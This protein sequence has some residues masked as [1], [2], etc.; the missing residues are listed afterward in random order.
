VAFV[1]MRDS[2]SFYKQILN[3][4]VLN[5][6]KKGQAVFIYHDRMVRA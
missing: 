3:E 1:K 2:V 4:Y 5:D 6:P